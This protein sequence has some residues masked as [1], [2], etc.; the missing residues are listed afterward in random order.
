MHVITLLPLFNLVMFEHYDARITL[1]KKCSVSW[2]WTEVILG[3]IWKVKFKNTII[4]VR[5]DLKI[6]KR[7]LSLTKI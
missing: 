3:L 1:S 6:V 4:V 2:G 5:H 7:L